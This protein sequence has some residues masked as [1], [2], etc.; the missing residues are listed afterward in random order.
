[1]HTNAR[2]RFDGA[3]T[4]SLKEYDALTALIDD[5]LTEFVCLVGEHSDFG[6][7]NTVGG[8]L[9]TGEPTMVE[10][11]ESDLKGA[12]LANEITMAL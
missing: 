4:L 9:F 3:F 8:F 7:N 10:E 11:S 12:V 5:K 1:V 2:P 6:L